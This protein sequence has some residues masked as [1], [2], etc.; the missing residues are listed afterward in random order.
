VTQTFLLIFALITFAFLTISLYWNNIVNKF[1][2]LTVYCFLASAVYF[3][4]DGAKGW[5]AEEPTEI[6][7]Q[8]ITVVIVNPSQS[9]PGGIYIGVFETDPKNWWQYSYPRY[10]PK[11]YFVRYSNNRAAEFE[12]ANQ[13][14]KE[15]RQVKIDGLPPMEG[16]G[17]GEPYDGEA[18]D[19]SQMISNMINKLMSKQDDTYTPTTPKNL[20]I[21]EEGS[22]PSKGN[23]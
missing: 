6:K 13:A 9:D 3:A 7:G 14:L 10:A 20:E 21:V 11:T 12:K 16:S 4:L 23:P 17:E 5:P 19:I 2:M 18:L 15:G 1:V 22:P 8:L